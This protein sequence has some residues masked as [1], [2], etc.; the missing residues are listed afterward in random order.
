M[1]SWIKFSDAESAHCKSSKNIT[2]GCSKLV[3]TW[4]NFWNNK[5]N[6]FCAA[7][8]DNSGAGG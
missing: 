7:V 1:S 3:K 4:V 5:L 2:N 8:P 6:L